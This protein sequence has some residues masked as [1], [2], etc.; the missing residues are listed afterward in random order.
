M[1]EPLALPALEAADRT[2]PAGVDPDAE[3]DLLPL[4]LAELEHRDLTP[5]DF[6]VRGQPL[7]DP[8]QQLTLIERALDLGRF[9]CAHKMAVA[10]GC[11]TRFG[12]G[13]LEW[14]L[15]RWTKARRAEVEQ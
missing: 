8:R 14:A 15:R 4:L 7:P 9:T 11:P 2:R 10:I 6:P 1:T 5:E 3:Q 12:G 13:R